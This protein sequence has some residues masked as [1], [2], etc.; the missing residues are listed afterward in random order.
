M[1][2]DRG[3]DSIPPIAGLIVDMDGVLYRGQTALP[4]AADLFPTLD[5]LGIRYLMV[6]NNSSLSPAAYAKKLA[7]LGIG[8]L[9]PAT[10]YTSALATAEWIAEHPHPTLPREEGGDDLTPF[11]VREGLGEG[12]RGSFYYVG[13]DSIREAMEAQGFRYDEAQPDYVVVGLDPQLTYAKLKIATLAIRSGATFV[14][15]NPDLTLPTEEGLVPGAGAIL[16]ALVAATG[17]QPTIIGKPHAPIMAQAIKLL[18]VPAASVAAL[19]DRLDTDID[20]G[21]SAGLMTIMVLTGVSTLAEVEARAVEARPDVVFA[22]LMELIVALQGQ[23]GDGT[24][25][26]S[27]DTRISSW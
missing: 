2:M 10:I 17:V 13:G 21:K 12:E 6:T 3:L 25:I 7:A 11:P 23:V 19:G 8:N 20:G 14:G 26:G 15:T 16:A 5:R 18:G 4:G 24:R 27:A 1:S 9:S 22:G